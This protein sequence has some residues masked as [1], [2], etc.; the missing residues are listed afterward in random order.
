MTPVQTILEVPLPRLSD[1]MEE[2]TVLRWIAEDGATVTVGEEIVEI[3]TDKATMTY[4]AEAE[5]VLE[6]VA[7]EG[8]TVPL[9]A[10]IARI[11]PPDAAFAAAP[12]AERAK[13]A[14]AT[15]GTARALAPETRAGGTGASQM[16][17]SDGS[18]SQTR[19]N[20]SPLARRL[21]AEHGVALERLAGSGPRGRIV[22]DDVLA[23]AR[24]ESA[25]AQGQAHGEPVAQEA[26]GNLAMP[27]APPAAAP[28]ILAGQPAPAPTAPPVERAAPALAQPAHAAAFD[29]AR[30]EVKILE[31][32]R[33][34]QLIARRMAEAKATAPE[35]V[36]TIEIDMSAAMEARAALS[37]VPGEGRLP[38]LNDLVVKAVALA[39]RAFP[40]ANGS[41][42]DGRWELYSRVN[43]G[44]AVA[45]EGGLLV[46]VVADADQKSLGQIA[47][48]TRA[49]AERVRSGS[50]TPPDVSGGTFTVSNLGMFGVT[51][52]AAVLNPPQAG[53][54][55]VGA[56]Q[57]RAVVR[58][59]Q[60][61]A[62]SIMAVT[63]TADHRILYGADAANFLA[64]IRDHLQEPRS[65]LL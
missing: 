14:S 37:A 55:A 1:Q 10:I 35:F 7:G 57:P 44:V 56:V 20:A 49:L 26:D 29:D 5:G 48:E 9:G 16:P 17:P 39:L 28:T 15:P 63:L 60:L 12:R 62:A 4:E 18:G 21:A 19:P 43:V 59:G 45:T 47:R 32:D 46:P 11:H 52:F 42:R 23:A 38:S 65:L 8:E 53:I 22:R 25:A 54:L 27:P 6:I 58:D 30:G 3:E 50:I 51:S 34:Q 64:R 2:G 41:Y 36:A 61:V 31:L 24:G 13:G 33:A 40:H